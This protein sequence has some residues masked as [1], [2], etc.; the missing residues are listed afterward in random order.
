MILRGLAI[1]GLA[2]LAAGCEAVPTLIFAD[3]GDEEA[4]DGAPADATP[5]DAASDAAPDAALDANCPAS[6]PPGA[7]VCCGAIGCE[8]LCSNMC[9][10][11]TSRCSAGE[12]CCA[13][14]NNVNCIPLGSKCH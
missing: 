10:M 3:A 1:V 2:A 14:N 4:Q 11:C 6:P 12:F 8:G 9:D 7:S 13:K 5:P